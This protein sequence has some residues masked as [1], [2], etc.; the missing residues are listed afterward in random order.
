MNVPD[1]LLANL[2]D[3]WP[4]A[5]LSSVTPR[6]R[7][8]TV[9]IVFCRDGVAIFSPIDGKTKNGRPLQREAN[10]ISNPRVAVLLDEYSSDWASL[11][12][13]RLDAQATIYNPGA[14]HSARL[15]TLLNAKYP[16]YAAPDLLP[17]HPTY[18]RISWNRASGWAQEDLATSL[19]RAVA[20][21]NP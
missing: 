11:W 5:H 21:D 2:L 20:S 12:W 15:R 1:A 6:G 17:D 19:G 10:I 9:P 3:V 4:V 18:L 7:P 8:H 14:E 13:V 16:Q